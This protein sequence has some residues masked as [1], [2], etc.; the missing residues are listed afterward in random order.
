M[1]VSLVARLRY[2]SHDASQHHPPSSF[3]FHW[4]L[5]LV[6]LYGE[7]PWRLA[8]QSNRYIDCETTQS[9]YLPAEVHLG[10]ATVCRAVEHVRVCFW[11]GGGAYRN[12][13][14]LPHVALILER[15][16]L[17]EFLDHYREML[18]LFCTEQYTESLSRIPRNAAV[19]STHGD[20]L[21]SRVT[22]IVDR[23]TGGAYWEYCL[24]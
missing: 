10:T 3:H 24:G 7:D 16:Q 14:F 15:C 4:C 12:E 9:H 13:F 22:S 23:A 21:R 1:R 18:M 8:G 6:Y 20:L 11:G 17:D 2:L 5:R 19:Q